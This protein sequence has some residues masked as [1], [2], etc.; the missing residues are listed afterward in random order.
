V[1]N[2]SEGKIHVGWYQ[3]RYA[4]AVWRDAKWKVVSGVAES[5]LHRSQVPLAIHTSV[6]V[7]KR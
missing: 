1:Q 4:R 5:R 7:A 3:C 6:Q 2:T